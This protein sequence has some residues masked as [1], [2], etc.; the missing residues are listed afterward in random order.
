LAFSRHASDGVL[1]AIYPFRWVNLFFGNAISLSAYP[2][3][4]AGVIRG[5]PAQADGS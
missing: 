2:S 3:T 4:S 5:L 1:I